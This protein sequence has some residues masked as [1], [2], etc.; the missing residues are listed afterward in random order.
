[1][2][3]GFSLVPRGSSQKDF[4]VLRNESR[5]D[6]GYW[7]LEKVQRENSQDL[8]L[9][10]ENILSQDQGCPSPILESLEAACFRCLLPYNIPESTDQDH[11]QASASLTD[12]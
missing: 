9:G 3:E 6:Q 12:V 8:Q 10:L 1:M 2:G 4:L 7:T 11:Y 5:I